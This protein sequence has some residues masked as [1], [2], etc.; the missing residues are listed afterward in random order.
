MLVDTKTNVGPARVT[1]VVADRVRLEMKDRT[2]WAQLAL[3]TPYR[4]ETGDVVLAIGDED[5]YVIG[6][7]TGR[8]KT[9]FES[10]GDL[11]LRA[12]GSV[13]IVG[14]EEVS[15]ESPRVRVKADRIET[16]ART[17]F[18]KCVTAYRWVRG[19]SRNR[20]GRVRTVVDGRYSVR[21]DQILERAKKD[22][23]INAEK[24]RLG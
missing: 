1:A 21:A 22:V 5:V 4:P 10:Q 8:G 14:G 24:I 13:R 19:L 17:V 6:V 7:L 15:L 23:S 12:R 11:E 2:A 18:E 16:I 20:A 3:S 9:V